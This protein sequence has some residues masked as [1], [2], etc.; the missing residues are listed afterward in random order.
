MIMDAP[1]VQY[2]RTS[3]GYDIAYAVRGEGRPFV[4]L[5]GAFEHVQ[6][7]WQYP[8]LHPWLEGLSTR[9]RLIQFDER[10][11]GMSTRGLRQDHFI[12]D[13]ERDLQA[14]VERLE[15]P[16][17]VLYAATIRAPAAIQFAL[18]HPD[19]ISALILG[20]C[21]IKTELS[22]ASGYFN[23]LPQQ[24]WELFLRSLVSL[25]QHPD[26]IARSVALQKQSFNVDD[27]VVRMRDATYPISEESLAGLRTP[28][29]VLHPRDY[30]ITDASDAVRVAQLA[31]ATMTLIDGSFALGDAEQGI[32][33]IESFL[34]SIPVSNPGGQTSL[35]ARLS[36][37]ELE[38]LHLLARGKSNQQI[39]DEL[40]ISL[41]TARKHVANILD[42]TATANRTE[43][44]GYARD[45]GLT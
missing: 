5:P 21:R 39:A 26:D 44:A 35:Q 4:L 25:Y 43:A 3:D 17:F 28:T 34:A 18:H 33:A 2:V 37:R 13:Y 23:V 42:K 38:V 20:P 30:A 12:T 29:L 22:R 7:A 36:S 16:P 8:S 9:F 10:G 27:F 45:H 6:L 1:P 11:A 24:N 15:L 40:V 31:R 19:R 32:R 14:V 41:N